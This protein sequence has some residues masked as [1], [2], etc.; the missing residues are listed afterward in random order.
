MFDINELLEV[1]VFSG[2]GVLVFAV[3]FFVMVKIAPFSVQ[4]EI[5]EDQNTSLGIVMGSVIIGLAL[6]ISAVIGGG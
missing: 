2:I 1:L 3:A 6:I 5:E 4:K